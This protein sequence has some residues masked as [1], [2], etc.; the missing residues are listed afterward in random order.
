MASGVGGL[1]GHTTREPDSR[2]DLIEGGAVVKHLVLVACFVGALCVGV[3]TTEAQ[4]PESSPPTAV[5]RRVVDEYWGQEV[6]DDYQYMENVDDPEVMEWVKGQDSYTRRVLDAYPH[7][8]ALAARVKEL[9]HSDSPAYWSLVHR[10]GL[11]FAIKRHPPRQQPFLVLLGSFTDAEDQRV[12]VDP[13]VID[14]TGST[15]ID[16]YEP[17]H[18]GRYVA[19]SLSQHGTED[20]TVHVYD[21]ETGEKLPDEIPRVNGGT[22]GGSVAWTATNDGFYYTRYPY[23]G[24]RPERDLFFYQQIWFHCLGTDLADD[25]YVLGETFPRIA[26][27]EMQTSDDGAR[28]L[29]EVSDGDGGEYEYW[30]MS[31]QGD[32][33]RFAEFKDWV[34]QARFGGDGAVYLLSR[35]D[36]PRKRI[37]RIPVETPELG[38]ATTAVEQT[39]SVITTFRATDSRLYVIE[40]VGGPTRLRTYD[41]DGR[42]VDL[43][44]MG[45]VTNVSGL[46][47][48]EG[49]R[50]L[51]RGESYTTPP[52]WYQY[53]PDVEAPEATVL[54]TSSPADFS[55]CTVERV[56]ASADDGT[57]IPINILMRAGTPMDGSAPLILY[58]YGS[59][60]SS[61]RPGFSATRRIWIEQGGIWAFASIRGGGEYGDDWHR[62]ANLEKKKTSMDD[63]AACA[64]H[65][66]E[67]GYTSVGRLAIEGGSAGGLL[68]Y[69]TMAHYPDR[70]AAVVSRVGISDALRT[71]LSPNG[72]FNITEFGT[73]KIE[74][75][76]HGMYAASPYHHVRNGVTYPAVLAL[77]GMNDPRVEPWQSFKMTARLQ[78]TGSPNPVLL[79]VSM[80][81]GHGG[82]T[83]LSERD[84]QRV[85]VYSFLFEALGVEYRTPE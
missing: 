76:Y 8:E 16:F 42:S 66:V 74:A 5:A 14:P 57:Q 39:E 44:D 19:V 30:L 29:A 80:G 67:S 84:A 7:R 13:N 53:G 77:T 48:L 36:A 72:E 75:Q 58:G 32:W 9:T 46:V 73:V 40:M 49:D 2:E 68:V 33:T 62:A 11:T 38:K 70:M 69:G 65:L 83:P 22:A 52:A 20:G 82:G 6:P 17:S 79:R 59:Y 4:A 51:V 21:V 15:S 63:F 55:D 35:K 24:E 71:E 85:D 45:D 50:V 54:A 12:L 28:V 27:I 81:S 23:P 31:P 41:L 26:E 61:Q 64:R 60:G 37:L 18:D 47:R 34:Q 3:G 78:A 43:M 25:Y 56:F 1:V 10:G